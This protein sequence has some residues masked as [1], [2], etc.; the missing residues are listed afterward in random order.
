MRTLAENNDLITGPQFAALVMLAHFRGGKSQE[1]ARLVMVD[2]LRQ[3]DAAAR[4]GITPAG[5]HNAVFRLAAVLSM[6]RHA[7]IQKPNV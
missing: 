1:A 2:G 6:A 5:V 7:V 3:V 4:V